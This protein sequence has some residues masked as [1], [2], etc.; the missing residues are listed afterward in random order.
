MTKS[1]FNN[2]IK[3]F[4]KKEEDNESGLGLK[5]TKTILEEHGFSIDCDKND[6]GTKIEIKIK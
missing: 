2:E 4:L 6:I 1:E 3:R 5:I